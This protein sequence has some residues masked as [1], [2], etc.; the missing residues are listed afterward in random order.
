MVAVIAEGAE[1]R[2]ILVIDT[3]KY[4]GNFER[5]MVAFMTGCV[6]DCG[7]GDKQA[8]R[9][10]AE[11]P[12]PP[13]DQDVI[14][15][16]PD[17]HGCCRPASIWVSPYY[18][19]NAGNHY[20]N[21]TATDDLRVVEDH[22]KRRLEHIEHTKRVYAHLGDEQVEE[23]VSRGTPYDNGPKRYPAY[24]SVAC[25][26][27]ERPDDDAVN[28]LM[29]RAKVFCA[30]NELHFIGARLLQQKIVEEELWC[31]YEG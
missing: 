21:Q 29:E 22:E 25:F 20:P 6:G 8:E 30:E 26:M 18:W 15:H 27:H 24:C 28:F 11:V 7:V 9:F 23:I 13:F 4:A 2:Y 3:D 17:E 16:E 1:D 31:R 5:E 12:S 19:N 14:A 10:D